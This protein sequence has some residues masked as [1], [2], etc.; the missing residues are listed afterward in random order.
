M[1]L[2]DRRP[3]DTPARNRRRPA[4]DAARR[5]YIS[6]ESGGGGHMRRR[7]MGCARCG[8]ALSHTWMRGTDGSLE[9]HRWCPRCDG[10]RTASLSDFARLS[11]YRQTMRRGAVS[12]EGWAA[13]DPVLARFDAQTR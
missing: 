4:T 12:F 6:E 3:Q 10:K 11:P 1:A 5:A 8:G 2:S 9:K 13:H 7:G